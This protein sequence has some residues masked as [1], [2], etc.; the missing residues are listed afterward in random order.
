MCWWEVRIVICRQDALSMAT[1]KKTG[2]HDINGQQ[3]YDIELDA[4]D[5][6]YLSSITVNSGKVYA[7]FVK[8]PTK[9]WRRT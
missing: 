1:N 3:Y 8:C 7:I 9:V 5:V 4:P 6:Q 2:E